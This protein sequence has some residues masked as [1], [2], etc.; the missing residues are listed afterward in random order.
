P[1]QHARVHA[2]AVVAHR[3]LDEAPGPRPGPAAALGRAEQA[4]VHLDRDLAA[5]AHRVARIDAEIQQ[6]LLELRGVAGPGAELLVAPDAGRDRLRKGRAQQRAHLADD[7]RD[8]DHL[9]AHRGAPRERQQAA[10]QL[11]AVLGRALE[12]EERL[13]ELALGGNLVEGEPGVA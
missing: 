1:A 4:V 6:D 3:E 13:A 10:R 11:R 9:R 5:L 8:V 2:H 12:L 7:A